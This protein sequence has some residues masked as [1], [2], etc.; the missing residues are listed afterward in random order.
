VSQK[1]TPTSS[2][3]ASASAKLFDIRILIG[4]LFTVYGVVLI[5]AGVFASAAEKLK[6]SGVNINLWTGIGM[7]ILGVLFLLW[8][9]LQP[10]KPPSEPADPERSTT[11]A[12]ARRGH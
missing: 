6:A 12:H 4:G 8:W 10:L 5:I 9:R 1:Q 7:L 11:T 2:Q 3:P